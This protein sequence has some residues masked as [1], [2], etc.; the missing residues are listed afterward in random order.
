MTPGD[1]LNGPMTSNPHNPNWVSQPAAPFD[2]ASALLMAARMRTL[3]EWESRARPD[4]RGRRQPRSAAGS[5]ASLL[6]T[7]KVK[8]AAQLTLVDRVQQGLDPPVREALGIASHSAPLLHPAPPGRTARYGKPHEGLGR[9]LDRLNRQLEA[10]PYFGAKLS[11]DQ[12]AENYE[13]Q[14]RVYDDIVAGWL[15]RLPPPD[16]L[17][18]DATGIR[19]YA[20]PG[21]DPDFSWVHQTPTHRDPV[22]T[23]YG[24][25]GSALTAVNL[26][27]HIPYPLLTLAFR[28]PL[29]PENHHLDLVALQLLDSWL[30]RGNPPAIMVTDSLYPHLRDWSLNLA[31]RGCGMI[32]DLQRQDAGRKGSVKG[33]ALI[34]GC[35]HCPFA[36]YR[37]DLPSPR[38]E[39]QALADYQ[40]ANEYRARFACQ[41]VA[42]TPSTLTLICPAQ[43]RLVRCPLWPDSMRLG[44]RYPDVDD[45]PASANAPE[46]CRGPIT[47]PRTTKWIRKIWMPFYYGGDTWRTYWSAG[48]TRAEED[49]GLLFGDNAQHATVGLTNWVGQARTGLIY[50]LDLALGNLH[51]VRKWWTTPGVPEL[52]PDTYVRQLEADPLLW[53]QERLV[54]LL[55]TILDHYATDGPQNLDPWRL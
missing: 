37:D 52:L 14:H 31:G 18:V 44:D 6:I 33:A 15:P 47:V 25:H 29:P 26:P 42:E 2:V 27:G 54:A 36:R 48:R 16:L 8:R 22:A 35:L 46:V 32:G 11:D 45:P 24:G 38:Q 34:D 13:W 17:T 28:L 3:P 50:A 39:G 49:F 21:K 5:I 30:A 7:L 40:A 1:N 19:G 10:S 4:P 12:R 55:P 41:V 20:R 43:A 9:H 53:P 51:V 23:I